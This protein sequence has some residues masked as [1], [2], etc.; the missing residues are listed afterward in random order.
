MLMI[1]I[2]LL[3]VL[4]NFC[5]SCGG[6]NSG[7]SINTPEAQNQPP[8]VTDVYMSGD[9]K[10]SSFIT[11]NY[12]YTDNEGD[13]EGQSRIEW[14]VN[15]SLIQSG[16]SPNYQLQESD[17]NGQISVSVTPVALSGTPSGESVSSIQL[18][19]PLWPI[20]EVIIE[21]LAPTAT[22]I[23]IQGDLAKSSLAVVSY[24]YNDNEE[25]LEGQ[26]R[27]EWYV[28]GSLI[29]SGTSKEYQLTEYD[30]GSK[31]SVAIHPVAISGSLVGQ[32]KMSLELEIPI[33][34][35]FTL[36]TVCPIYLKP[37]TNE[38]WPSEWVWQSSTKSVDLVDDYGDVIEN[39][40]SGSF[41]DYNGV[42]MH[43]NT[44]WA[45]D[46]K[47][48]KYNDVSKLLSSSSDNLLFTCEYLNNK[49]GAV[50]K[51]QQF[52]PLKGND[53]W[54]PKTKVFQL[55]LNDSLLIIDMLSDTHYQVY[56]TF[57]KAGLSKN[58]AL[59]SAENYMND[60][61][62]DSVFRPLNMSEYNTQAKYYSLFA[63]NS[64][65]ANYYKT[66]QN[67][68]NQYTNNRVDLLNELI[69]I[70]YVN[71][72]TTGNSCTE[73]YICLLFINKSTT[74][75]MNDPLFEF[76]YEHWLTNTDL[77]GGA[78]GGIST[79]ITQ[80]TPRRHNLILKMEKSYHGEEISNNQLEVYQVIE[81]ITVNDLNSMFLKINTFNL[82]AGC[83]AFAGFCL[84]S[85]FA[86][87]YVCFYQD[88]NEIQ[89]G[90][91]LAGA[92]DDVITLPI[93]IGEYFKIE[94]TDRVY[95]NDIPFSSHQRVWNLKDII[96]ENLPFANGNIESISKVLV[97]AVV[98]EFVSPESYC[99]NCFGELEATEIGIYTIK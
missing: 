12:T 21:N 7:K 22:N 10:K 48:D 19:I 28:N 77:K 86:G 72:E 15:G 62:S 13:L 61:F 39:L 3:I 60:N 84:S 56:K 58:K 18:Q 44:S 9:F 34:F 16:T 87:Y 29:Q 85:G 47:R 25:D 95:Y 98:G 41:S 40:L 69:G 99:Q 30:G 2:I 63:E 80:V 66:F 20:E 6:D 64:L 23:Q 4:V 74:S 1:R 89:L 33:Y 81:N 59:S 67:A 90:C 35:E 91:M 26:S 50:K 96:E 73:K 83:E 17:N 76:G 55:V 70:N 54:E 38:I 97:G 5:F 53:Y 79:T 75:V 71:Y 82:D 88:D 11:I 32:M 65:Q 27:I 31:L 94:S 52:V 42:G 93:Y 92:W 51:F 37:I 43:N 57:M 14:Y 49:T 8:V 36:R 24:D 78:T 68:A 46:Y 45:L